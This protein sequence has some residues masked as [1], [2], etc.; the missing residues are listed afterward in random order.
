MELLYHFLKN[1]FQILIEHEIKLNMIGDQ[2]LLPDKQRNELTKVIDATKDHTKLTLT[3]ALSYGG[4][5]EITRATQNIAQDIE[6]KKISASDIDNNLLASYLDTS[7]MPDPDLLIRTSGE[8]RLSNFLLWQLSYSELYFTDTL[9]P[10]FDKAE[11]Q[12]A[13]DCYANR[14]RRF[15]KRL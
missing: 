14:E 3:L 8:Q 13:I 9:W 11:F 6:D 7:G 10:D 1:K 4:R 12:K 2:S 5:D 15:G